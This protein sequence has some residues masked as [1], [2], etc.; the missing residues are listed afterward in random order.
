MDDTEKG[1]PM[2]GAWTMTDSGEFVLNPAY[3]KILREARNRGMMAWVE[4]V[5]SFLA[6]RT[7]YTEEEL[8]EAFK[9]QADVNPNASESVDEFVIRALEGDLRVGDAR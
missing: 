7:S 1:E 4:A 3:E 6:E 5:M 8:F 2:T 9:H